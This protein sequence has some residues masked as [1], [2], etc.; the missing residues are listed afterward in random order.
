MLMGVFCALVAGGIFFFKR[1]SRSHLTAPITETNLAES[2]GRVIRD[3]T[4]Q[5]ALE[6]ERTGQIVTKGLLK[7]INSH[8]L[9]AVPEGLV[10]GLEVIRSAEAKS[11]ILAKFPEATARML[12]R[13]S[14][15]QVVTK[16]G[17]RLLVAVDKNG[18]KFI[19]QAKQVDPSVASI[20]SQIGTLIVGA[21]HIIAG[22]DN[23][24][25]LKSIEGKIDVLL[26]RDSNKLIARLGSVYEILKEQ[27]RRGDNDKDFRIQLLSSKQDLKEIRTRYF[28]N[29]IDELQ[30]VSDPQK[31][32]LPAKL[33]SRRKTVASRLVGE[34]SKHEESLRLIRFALHLEQVI[35]EVIGDR[36]AFAE[37]TLPEV[38]TYADK[39]MSLVEERNSWIEMQR[40]KNETSRLLG[41]YI[42]F[43][44]SLE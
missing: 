31:R 19:S 16:H 15:V 12:E 8:F 10:V 20:L 28:L 7:E 41:T 42:N 14:A 23:A 35:S 22:Y 27:I 32:S 26:A 17:E 30:R 1:A 38:R 18:R 25:K 44:N 5:E 34:V 9:H 11:L 2:F 33:F 43:K 24:K 21:A 3:V 39:L 13:G 40:T 4:F 36:D 37:V 6:Y 29:V